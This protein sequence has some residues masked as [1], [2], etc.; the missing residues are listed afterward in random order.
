MC[1]CSMFIYSI[2]HAFLLH[3]RARTDLQLSLDKIYIHGVDGFTLVLRRGGHV[4]A[5]GGS[6]HI[7]ISLHGTHLIAFEIKQ[8][9]I[10]EL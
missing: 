6:E 2:Y 7:L 5:K 3:C 1:R 10:V 9:G 4:V 8:H